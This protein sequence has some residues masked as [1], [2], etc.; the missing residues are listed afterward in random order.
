M[1]VYAAM[2]CEC[3]YE[4]GF[5]VIS[6]HT[7]KAAAYKVCREWWVAEWVDWNDDVRGS[8]YHGGMSPK[9]CRRRP[10]TATRNKRWAVKAMQVL[11]DNTGDQR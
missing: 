11:P 10:D 7:T 6:L 2:K 3:V 8:G 4:S 9:E 5:E 1:I